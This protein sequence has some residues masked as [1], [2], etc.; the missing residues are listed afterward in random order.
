MVSLESI[1]ANNGSEWNRE[2]HAD[3]YPLLLALQMFSFVVSVAL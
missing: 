2:G 3:A 1:N